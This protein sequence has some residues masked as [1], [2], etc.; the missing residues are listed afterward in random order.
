MLTL[1]AAT[2]DF[3]QVGLLFCTE[4]GRMYFDKLYAFSGELSKFIGPVYDKFGEDTPMI[5]SGDEIVATVKVQVSPTFRG[6]LHQ[7]G[8]EMRMMSPV[9][10][11]DR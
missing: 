7:F 2:V 6:W 1:V 9:G 4:S 5:R 3:V 11:L 10:E 8:G